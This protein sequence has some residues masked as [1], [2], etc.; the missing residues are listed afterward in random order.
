MLSD[1]RIPGTGFLYL[2]YPEPS[3][4]RLNG[5]GVVLVD[6][7]GERGTSVDD[8]VS[9][10]SPEGDIGRVM[11]VQS[12]V[13]ELHKARAERRGAIAERP[14]RSG[15]AGRRGLLGELRE[16]CSKRRV[17]RREDPEKRR[18]H[19]WGCQLE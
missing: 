10:L 13:L 15:H 12:R 5:A 3:V 2:F 18:M 14:H 1:G 16:G 17:C 8:E 11:L 6:D 19:G 7:P 9:R 4:W